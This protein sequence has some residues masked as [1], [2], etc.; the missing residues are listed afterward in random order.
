M[1]TRVPL[2]QPFSFTVRYIS[3]NSDHL[4]DT[5]TVEFEIRGDEP[6]GETH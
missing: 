3:E 2:K 6:G 4:E 1:V 5:E